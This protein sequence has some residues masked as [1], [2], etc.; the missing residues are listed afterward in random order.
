MRWEGNR[1]GYLSYRKSSI[2]RNLSSSY[3]LEAGNVTDST[4]DG[5][6]PAARAVSKADGQP[7]VLDLSNTNSPSITLVDDSTILM[8]ASNDPRLK[9]KILFG[10]QDVIMADAFIGIT[11]AIQEIAS[12]DSRERTQRFTLSPRAWNVFLKVSEYADQHRLSP[13]FLNYAMTAKSLGR[14]ARKMLREKRYK[15]SVM[16]ITYD[17]VDVG[18][19]AVTANID[20]DVVAA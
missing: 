14:L 6:V 16:V 13:P 18:E 4:I 10:E 2:D 15:S 20:K 5:N 12:F 7:P 11:G 3:T 1:V 19:V 9:V 8:D 17:G